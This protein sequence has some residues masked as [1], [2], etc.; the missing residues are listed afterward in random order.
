MK[1]GDID[2]RHLKISRAGEQEGTLQNHPLGE[3]LG[4]LRLRKS[5]AWWVA[6]WR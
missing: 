5:Q 1:K 2:S 6:D 4:M 3:C